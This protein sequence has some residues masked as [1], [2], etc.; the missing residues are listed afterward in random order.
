MTQNVLFL[1]VGYELVDSTGW[2]NTCRWP[3]VDGRAP[4]YQ[5]VFERQFQLFNLAFDLSREFA[6]G[7]FLQ[8]GDPQ[9]QGLNHL[10][11]DA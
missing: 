6:K 9:T 1:P 4:S 5:Q 11:M 2:R 3:M 8:L 7:L 10:V